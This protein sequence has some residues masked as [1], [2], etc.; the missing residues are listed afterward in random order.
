MRAFKVSSWYFL[1]LGLGLGL[2][3]SS[4]SVIEASHRCR[5]MYAQ[6]QALQTAQWDMQ[7]QQGR[8]LLEHS[9]WAGHH[10]VEQLARKQLG[11]R[12]PSATELQVVQP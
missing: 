10:R 11:M 6:L 9:T 12:L 8:L 7:E 2:A 1:N 5:Q 4:L 3:A